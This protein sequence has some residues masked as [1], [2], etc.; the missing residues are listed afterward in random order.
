MSEP[1]KSDADGGRS[2]VAADRRR[3]QRAMAM[4]RVG[5]ITGQGG[6]FP[7]RVRSL[8]SSGFVAEATTPPSRGDTVILELGEGEP[9]AAVVAWVRQDRFGVAFSEAQDPAILLKASPA[10]HG[11]KRRPPRFECDGL[12]VMRAG[13]QYHSVTVTNVS[14][15]GLCVSL[16]GEV[17]VGEQ[18]SCEIDGLG[19]VKGVVRW[20]RDGKLGISFNEPLAYDHLAHWIWVLSRLR[21]SEAAG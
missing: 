11:H 14:Q 6:A 21:P 10:A 2:S 3:D 1:P 17:Q 5:K 20:C 19:W 8:S 12:G 13:S 18:V 15:N 4:L 16:D 9:L 7:C